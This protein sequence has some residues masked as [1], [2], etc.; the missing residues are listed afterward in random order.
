[1]NCLYCHK[2]V[3]DCECDTGPKVSTADNVIV[4]F[5]DESDN[6]VVLR[7]DGDTLFLEVNHLLNDNTMFAQTESWAPRDF[8]LLAEAWLKHQ[9]YTVTSGPVNII[10][11]LAITGS[12]DGK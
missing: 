4:W 2:P 1:M 3:Y 5:T 10:A 12:E 6:G 8:T 9:G 11:N 7:I